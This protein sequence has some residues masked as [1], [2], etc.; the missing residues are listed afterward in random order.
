MISIEF[1]RQFRIAGFAIFDFAV[2]FIGVYLLA[3]LLSKLFGKLG[4][5]IL[6]KNWLFLTIPLSVLIH[7]LVS[8]I[9]PMTK[10]FLDP[11]GHFILKGVIIIL[12]IF[13]LRGIKRVKK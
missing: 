4:I 5:Q 11:Q 12:L 2:S 9:T 8:Q 7:V 13:G 3:P 1:L 6:K 10:E